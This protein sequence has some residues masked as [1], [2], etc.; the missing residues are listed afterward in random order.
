M[1]LTDWI[2]SIGVFMIL[3]AYFLN[4]THK[5]KSNSLLFVL[6]N[7]IGAI[8]ACV[9]SVLIDYLPFVILEAT[10][11]AVSVFALIRLSIDRRKA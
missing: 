4:V 10:W 3:L 8:M 7:L 1:N 9:A 5:I 6:L 2:G 11:A